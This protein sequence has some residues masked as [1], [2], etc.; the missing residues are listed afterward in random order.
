[1]E[2]NESGEILSEDLCGGY[3]NIGFEGLNGLSMGFCI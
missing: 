3:S 1:M 2:K